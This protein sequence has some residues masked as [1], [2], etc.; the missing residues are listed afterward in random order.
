MG[1]KYPATYL[2]A[3]INNYF[4]YVYPGCIFMQCSY[5]WSETC[6]ARVNEK[7]GSDF[8]YPEGLD[9]YR[10][11]LETVR[12]RIFEAYPFR[13]INMPGMTTWFL[14]IWAFWLIC[15]RKNDH[16]M[17]AVPL[18]IVML[19]CFASPC[20]GYYCRYQYPL[21]A[22]LPWAILAGRNGK[23]CENMRK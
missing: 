17:L 1:K 10:H 22:Y 13:L 8:H 20:N 7:I 5:D 16:L 21:L 12:E 4:E 6:F 14:L 3:F 18:F 11:G 9:R 2:N 23:I 15:S 19:V